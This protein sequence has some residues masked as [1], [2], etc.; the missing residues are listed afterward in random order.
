LL[1]LQLASPAPQPGMNWHQHSQHAPHHWLCRDLSFLTLLLQQPAWP[2]P[3]PG[4]CRRQRSQ[5]ATH[6]WPIHDYR[7]FVPITLLL[8]QLAW[9]VQQPG[10]WR[11]PHPLGL[12]LQW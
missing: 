2:A 6:N 7:A 5:H 12:L 9:R 3:Q 4:M 10:M 11:G 1:L 8:L